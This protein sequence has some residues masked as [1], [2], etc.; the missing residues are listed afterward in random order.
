MAR[1]QADSKIFVPNQADIAD[2][3]YYPE[4]PRPQ[5]DYVNVRPLS[6]ETYWKENFQAEE[7]TLRPYQVEL[8]CQAITGRSTIICAPTGSGKTHGIIYSL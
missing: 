3:E 4:E 7:V 1:K 2:S 8:A 5:K 6:Y